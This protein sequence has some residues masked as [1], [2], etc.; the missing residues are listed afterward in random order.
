MSGDVNVN[1][2]SIIR[3]KGE[4]GVNFIQTVGSRM[5]NT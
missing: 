4:I 2:K 3:R 5:V 1:P